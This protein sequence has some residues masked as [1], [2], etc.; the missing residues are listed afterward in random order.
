MSEDISVGGYLLVQSAM[1][2]SHYALEYKMPWLVL[3][4]PTIAIIPF[5]VFAAVIAA[6]VSG[7]KKK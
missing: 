6:L 2:F 3:W 1:L 7:I 5:L 4:F